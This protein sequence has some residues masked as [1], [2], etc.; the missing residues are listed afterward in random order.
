MKASAELR[1]YTSDKITRDLLDG[2]SD[3]KQYQIYMIGVDDY[4]RVMVLKG[5][6]PVKLR[7]NEYALNY[8]VEEKRSALESFMKNGKTLDLNGSMLTPAEN[9]LFHQT[10]INGN[11]FADGGTLI[12]S[13]RLTEGLTLTWAVCNGSFRNSDSYRK[14]TMDY[15]QVPDRG[16]CGAGAAAII[17][18]CG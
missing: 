14:L 7:D 9:G 4:N 1:I 12:V 18:G 17:P 11:G 8:N 3:L 2:D 5:I 6:S 13:Q 10:Y 16:R 15:L